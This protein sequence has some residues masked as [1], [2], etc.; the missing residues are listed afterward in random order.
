[1]FLQSKKVKE[2]LLGPESTIDVTR[3]PYNQTFGKRSRCYSNI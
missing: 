1:M 3:D 2:S